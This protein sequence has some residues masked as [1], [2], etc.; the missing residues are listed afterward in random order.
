MPQFEINTPT[1]PPH[2]KPLHQSVL[3]CLTLIKKKL[4]E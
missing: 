4:G 1:H 3:G 2:Q